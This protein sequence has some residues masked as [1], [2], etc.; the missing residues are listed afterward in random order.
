MKLHLKRL[1]NAAFGAAEE[2]SLKKLR[3][4]TCDAAEQACSAAGEP[5][6]DRCA[7]KLEQRP[8]V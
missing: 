2:L 5:P 8:A 7:P 4:R 3:R 6:P 1:I